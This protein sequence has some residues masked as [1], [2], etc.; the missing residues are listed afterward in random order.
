MVSR[1]AAF[2]NLLLFQIGRSCFVLWQC[3]RSSRHATLVVCVNRSISSLIRYIVLYYN[4]SCIW[5]K[6]WIFELLP[7]T[8]HRSHTRSIIISHDV[9]IYVSR[10]RI[11]T[12]PPSGWCGCHFWDWGTTTPM[13]TKNDLC[14]HQSWWNILHESNQNNTGWFLDTVKL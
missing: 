5:Y 6:I 7:C 4:N 8:Q 12:V 13:L 10:Y 9:W 1:Q 3:D 11:Y 2:S 14:T